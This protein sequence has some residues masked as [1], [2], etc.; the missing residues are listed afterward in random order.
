MQ[1]KKLQNQLRKNTRHA[2]ERIGAFVLIAGTLAGIVTISSDARRVLSGLALRPA[3]A[4]IE[5]SGKENETARHDV[6]LDSVLRATPSSGG[7]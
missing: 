4:V 1:N 5:H 2:H 6:R 7:N 3:F